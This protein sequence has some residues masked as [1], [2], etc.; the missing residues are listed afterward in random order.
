MWE[1]Y[2]SSVRQMTPHENHRVA[3]TKAKSV[4]IISSSPLYQSSLASNTGPALYTL[5]FVWVI[6]LE[7]LIL[8]TN[9]S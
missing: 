8:V 6:L 4:A 5:L 1:N 7:M 9:S 2:I 3:E